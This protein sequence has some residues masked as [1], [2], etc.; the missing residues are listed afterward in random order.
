[1]A[2]VRDKLRSICRDCANHK[3]VTLIKRQ[4]S[5]ATVTGV[6]LGGF[7]MKTAELILP[8]IYGARPD[9]MTAKLLGYITGIGLTISTN[10]FYDRIWR[11]IQEAEQL[12]SEIV[13]EVEQEEQTAEEKIQ[14]INKELERELSGNL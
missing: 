10:I 9:H 13:Q 4:T 7:I 1:M 6:L 5:R 8:M 11:W 12:A 2:R 3:G 14:D